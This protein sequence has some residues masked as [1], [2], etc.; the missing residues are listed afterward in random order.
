MNSILVGILAFCI[1]FP[2]VFTALTQL[3]ILENQEYIIEE[4]EYFRENLEVIYDG[5][6]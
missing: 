2:I 1:I 3:D 6:S 4:L 5:H